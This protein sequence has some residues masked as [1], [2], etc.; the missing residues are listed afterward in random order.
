MRRIHQSN[1]RTARQPTALLLG[2]RNM[3]LVS[4]SIIFGGI[5]IWGKRRNTR[6]IWGEKRNT[7]R[8]EEV[9][10][11]ESVRMALLRS[12][13][14]LLSLHL[15]SRCTYLHLLFSNE[16]IWLIVF[17]TLAVWW[18]VDPVA[19]ARLRIPCLSCRA[20]IQSYLLISSGNVIFAIL[21]GPMFR[22]RFGA[23]GA[24]D[25]DMLQQCVEGRSHNVRN[26]QEGI[27]RG[28]IQ[29]G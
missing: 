13:I 29:L 23:L 28:S 10:W 20:L 18:D 2:W 4:L 26:V 11:R 21:W 6:R 27:V 3:Y 5:Q 8:T 24:K 7:R 17:V 9:R 16:V 19:M 1:E 14:R 12:E 25:S 22:T 15:R